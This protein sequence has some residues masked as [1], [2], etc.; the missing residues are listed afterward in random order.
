VGAAGRSRVLD[1]SALDAA[2]E[3]VPVRPVE[4]DDL[5][6]LFLPFKPGDHQAPELVPDVSA[7]TADSA[8]PVSAPT[9]AA[10]YRGGSILPAEAPSIVNATPPP[11]PPTAPAPVRRK[12]GT[13]ARAP[14]G[15]AFR[16]HGS[17]R[18]AAATR[19]GPDDGSGD[20]EP[21]PSSG[22]LLGLTHAALTPAQGGSA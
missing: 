10:R 3:P 20:P 6:G 5:S 15:R 16:R 14:R 8:I 18:G 19:A 12:C 11:P 1:V 22:R 17:R 13:R 7:G 9:P 2:A 4:N 21:G